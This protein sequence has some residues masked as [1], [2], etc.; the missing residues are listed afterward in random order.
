[1]II[2]NLLQMQELLDPLIAVHKIIEE[3]SN[4]IL[5]ILYHKME[6]Q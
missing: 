5:I 2:V 3:H 4:R 1:M 6:V